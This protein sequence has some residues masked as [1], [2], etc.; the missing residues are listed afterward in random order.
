MSTS[1][2]NWDILQ[3]LQFYSDLI[4]RLDWLPFPSSSNA[5]IRADWSMK[6]EIKSFNY[7]YQHSIISDCIEILPNPLG[8][9]QTEFN[10][11]IE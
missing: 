9:I 4:Y 2:D 11:L 3:T 8:F 10:I 5:W 1:H 7:K 6:K